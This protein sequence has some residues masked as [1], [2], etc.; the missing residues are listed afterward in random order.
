MRS[1]KIKKNIKKKSRTK[2]RG[3]NNNIVVSFT[4]T[5]SRIDNINE[6]VSSIQSQS[7]TPNEIY[8]NIPNYSLKEK[9]PYTT[10][11]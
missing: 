4:T 2:Q 3:G 1:K 11:E 10:P 5:H 7:L 9:K 6:V 8:G